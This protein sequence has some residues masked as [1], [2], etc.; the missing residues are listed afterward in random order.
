MRLPPSL[1]PRLS[2][3]TLFYT[4]DILHNIMLNVHVNVGGGEPEW[5]WSHVDT[6]DAFSVLPMPHWTCQQSPYVIKAA[7]ALTLWC[8]NVNFM[9]IKHKVEGES[10]ET[11]LVTTPFS[12]AHVQAGVQFII[13]EWSSIGGETE[14]IHTRIPEQWTWR[15]PSGTFR[16]GWQV[17]IAYIE[18]ST[19][20]S[21][22]L[23]AE[24]I[25]SSIQ[26]CRV[27]WVN[28]Q[29]PKPYNQ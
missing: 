18:R 8:L 12:R 10:L 27:D 28:Y 1:V 4:C 16:D 21:I 29:Q 14:E 6:G 24:M 26:K 9:Y 17:C 23:T 2:P 20:E 25:E 15:R 13:G 22:N 7:Q 19:P 5:L 3:I 11:R